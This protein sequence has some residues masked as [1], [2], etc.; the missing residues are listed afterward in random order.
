MAQLD[1]SRKFSE[2]LKT[3]RSEP[4]SPTF[5]QLLHGDASTW[6]S[7]NSPTLGRHHDQ[8]E[9]HNHHSRKSVLTKVKERA[10]KLR[11]SLSPKKKNGHEFHDGVTTPPWGVTLP[12]DED[13]DE[14]PEYFGAPMY[15]SELAPENYKETAKQHPREVHVASEK[16]VLTSS[17]KHEALQKNEEPS[18][19]NKTITETVSEKLGPAYTAVSETVSEKLGPAYA[20]VTDATHTIASKIAGLT[21]ATP[22]PTETGRNAHPAIT[23]TPRSADT[24]KHVGSVVKKPGRSWEIKEQGT[25]SPQTWDKGVS[26]KEYL[27][28]KLEP[29]EDERALSQVISEAISPRRTPGDMGMVEKMRE[30]VTSF[31]RPEESSNS[32]TK[33]SNLTSDIPISSN[34]QSSSHIPVFATN[35][36]S[37][38]DPRSVSQIPISATNTSSSL[39]ASRVPTSTAS[40]NSSSLISHIP[41]YTTRA[42]SS[43]RLPISSNAHEV[44]P[45]MRLLIAVVEE[46]NHG[47]TLQ[48]N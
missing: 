15:E 23:T 2:N 21:V 47:R 4:T 28:Q 44:S 37:S 8:E 42:N 12:D 9:D 48:T 14:D 27:M 7:S 19:P 30:A 3:P 38:S 10:K 40:A 39:Q 35:T 46:D 32:G 1:P 31:L 26:V 33:T 41:V 6:S 24:K 5:E 22:D 45:V 29:G 18:G 43:S 17:I 25:S 16:H 36:S 13:D 34:T 11:H 20:A